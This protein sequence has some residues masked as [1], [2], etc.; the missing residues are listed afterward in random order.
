MARRTKKTIGIRKIKNLKA[1]ARKIDAE[2]SAAIR[3][4][5]QA[6]FARH[7]QLRSIV[8]T[9][10]ERRLSQGLTLAAIARKSG[11]AKPNL[12]RL[13]NSD[14]IVPTLDTLERYARAVG[15]TI[16]VELATANAA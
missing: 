15:M 9:L 10:R 3:T 5:G 7:E 12:S 11:I 8:Q 16:H 1:L 2:E 13:E 4:R 6:A 14:R